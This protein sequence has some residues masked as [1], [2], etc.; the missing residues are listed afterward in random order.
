MEFDDGVVKGCLVLLI[1]CEVVEVCD[2]LSGRVFR[3]FSFLAYS[4]VGLIGRCL[5]EVYL[6]VLVV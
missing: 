3:K 6:C 5:V 2:G 1:L 4:I